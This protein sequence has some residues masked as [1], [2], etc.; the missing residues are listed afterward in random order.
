MQSGS[1]NHNAYNS[2]LQPVA[3]TLR[4]KATKAEAC[5]WKYVL[6]AGQMKGYRFRRQ[7][8]VLNY[9]VD[10]MCQP[11][12]LIIELDGGVHKDENVA[13]R[14]AKRQAELQFAGFTLI[15]FTNIEVLQTIEQ[16]RKRIAEW[17]E[18]YESKELGS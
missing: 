7:R 8:P 16:V 4:N 5:L 1:A 15:R 12:M 13:I 17:I 3:N 10:F 9:V 2:R 11:L 18:E 14:D 6:R